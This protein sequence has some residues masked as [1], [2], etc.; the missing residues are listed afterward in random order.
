MH[1]AP[2][3]LDVGF[4]ELQLCEQDGQGRF[5]DD[6]HRDLR[7]AG[8]LDCIDIMDQRR[9]YRAQ[10]GTEYWETCGALP[11]DLPEALHSTTWIANRALGQMEN[12]DASG[13]S[14][15]MCGFVKPHHPFDPPAPWNELYNPDEIELLPGWSETLSE[16]DAQFGGYFPN[17]ELTPEKMRRVTAY[18][19]ATISQI[20]FQLGRIIALLKAKGFYE[21][22][23]IVFASDHGEYLGFH[24]LLLKSGPMYEPLM[25]VPL[26]IKFATNA[27]AGTR[28]TGLT[29]LTDLAP[30][31]L[32]AAAVTP[33]ATMKGRDL[34]ANQSEREF[35]F[36]EDKLGQ[37]VMARSAR[38]KLLWSLD[39]NQRRF[40]DLQNDPLETT[41]LLDDVNFADEIARHRAALAN[42]GL[43]EALPPTFLDDNAP[44]SPDL[45]PDAGDVAAR[46]EHREIMRAWSAE[47]FAEYLAARK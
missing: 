11:S 15:L 27:R 9:E 35:I 31:L 2:T 14:L 12:W 3:Y 42:W 17:A 16:C 22:T 41:N 39:E 43:F 44:M 45:A 32:Q 33:P 24:H 28:E 7:D 30:T 29:M 1:F 40:F 8:R 20:D 21:N 26:L 37:I 23:I 13:G 4:D 38:Y 10:A 5:E 18:Y 19:F 34:S 47:K 46:T 36:A 25:R 6:Y